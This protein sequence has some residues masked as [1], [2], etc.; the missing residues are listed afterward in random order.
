MVHSSNKVMKRM[1][2][3]HTFVS[4]VVR[5]DRFEKPGERTPR[6]PTRS[7]NYGRISILLE[8]SSRMFYSVRLCGRVDSNTKPKY[9][10]ID[11]P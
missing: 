6:A 3:I 10:S 4:V 1:T 5:F 9:L 2:V 11:V 7:R 8:I